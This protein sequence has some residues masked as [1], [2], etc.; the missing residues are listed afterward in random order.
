MQTNDHARI[1]AAYIGRLSL[2]DARRIMFAYERCWIEQNSG[3]AG[4][5]MKA[6]AVF[7]ETI[8]EA[9]ARM[10]PSDRDNLERIIQRSTVAA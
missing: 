8:A 5:Q 1:L 10:L 3:N 2:A 6:D 7:A 4:S 9:I